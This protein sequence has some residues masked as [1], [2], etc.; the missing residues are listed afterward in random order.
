MVATATP[1]PAASPG[2]AVATDTPAPAVTAEST[3]AIA[4]DLRARLEALPSKLRDEAL[5]GY[6]AGDVSLEQLDLIARLYEERN[7]DLRVGSVLSVSGD[8]LRFEVYTTGEAVEVI[9]SEETAVRRGGDSI[10]PEDLQ[11]GE[12]VMVLTPE[13]GVV[14]RVEAFGVAVP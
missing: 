6:A 7:P 11:P 5:S 9:L 3:A 1:A 12:L 4:D 14:A 10:A 13:A 2:T 8:R